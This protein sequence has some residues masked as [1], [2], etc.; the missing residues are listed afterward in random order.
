[1]PVFL[2]KWEKYFNKDV[3]NWYVISEED[4]SYNLSGIGKIQS[5]YTYTVG[6]YLLFFN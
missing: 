1:M 3:L 5:L 4:F 6:N 2:E